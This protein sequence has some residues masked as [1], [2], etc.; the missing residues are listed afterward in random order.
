MWGA[1]LNV[2]AAL[3]E[4][5][6]Q[7]FTTE[8]NRA[9]CI[10]SHLLRF[11][12]VTD[13]VEED[14]LICAYYAARYKRIGEKR[15]DFAWDMAVGHNNVQL[16]RIM[17]RGIS[18]N[19]FHLYGSASSFHLIWIYFMNHVGS[20]MLLEFSKETEKSQRMI[21]EHYKLGYA[22]ESIAAKVLKAALIRV[23]IVYKIWGLELK[24]EDLGC[25]QRMLSKKVRIGD[26]DFRIEMD[27]GL[28]ISIYCCQIQA[29]IDHIK[30]LALLRGLGELSDYALLGA[31][32]SQACEGERYWFAGERKMMYETLADE[33][34]DKTM[35][36]IY[37][38]WFYAY[39]VIKQNVRSELIQINNAVG[40]ENFQIYSGRK[41]VY[42]DYKKMIISAVHGSLESGNIRC[43]EI[44]VSP[45]RSAVENEKMLRDI[46]NV[47]KKWQ[48]P[49]QSTDYYFVFHF[50]KGKDDVLPE[51]EC[52]DGRRCRH[53]RKRKDLEVQANAVYHFR[54]K[55][56]QTAQKVLGIDACA[57]EIGCRPEVFAVVFRFLAEH[58]A[59][60]VVGEVSVAQLKMTY[61]VGE[62]FLDVVD[63]LRA[64]D[65]AVQFLNLQCGDRIGHGTVL[66]IDVKKWYALKGN[67]ILI[68]QQDYLDNVVWLYHKLTEYVL[69][70]YENLKEMLRQEF[71][72]YFSQI[73]MV[74]EG[75]KDVIPDI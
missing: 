27:E 56:R 37:Y 45:K 75:G 23:C 31:G 1:G 52:F 65:E 47:I 20:G 41:N 53:Y 29:M 46:D 4:L 44:R 74:S 38:Q 72:F 28:D 69:Q 36:A 16:R 9:V 14:L 70:D 54:E 39:L 5:A 48:E 24:Q 66:G 62:D 58:V 51:R 49:L 60:D 68:S 17:E 35:S 30:D 3:E 34:A 42:Q 40:F 73:Y 61:H 6:E 57:Q 13:Y 12:Q 7:L 71:N 18:E 50:A 32:V 59:E 21:R 19:H 33:L 26:G 43:L 15:A 8:N 11:R 63:G 10:Y 67:T 55:Y 22:E 2:F 25:I 64:V